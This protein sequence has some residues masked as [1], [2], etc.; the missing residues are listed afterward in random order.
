MPKFQLLAVYASAFAVLMTQ[1]AIAYELHD[2][3]R[4]CNGGEK[5]IKCY[6][7]VISKY[8]R[9]TVDRYGNKSSYSMVIDSVANRSNLGTFIGYGD[10]YV[11]TFFTR[12]NDHF[13]DFDCIINSSG[14][15]LGIER[16]RK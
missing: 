13:A 3:S 15:I 4:T 1:S 2:K 14:D 11:F 16:M 9:T 8:T 10:N 7:A 12:I 5:C 6:D